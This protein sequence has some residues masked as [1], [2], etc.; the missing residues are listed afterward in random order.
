MGDLMRQYWI[1]ALRSDELPSPDCPPLRVRLLG[2]DLIAFRDHVRR[3]RPDAERL[4][5]PRRLDVL[6]PQRRRR[7]ALRLPR[8]EVR[9]RPAPASTCRP[10]RPSRNFKNKV[11]TRGL[12]DAASA[13]ASSGPTWARART[14]PPLP[15]LE[16]N[17][18]PTGERYIYDARSAS[19]TGCRAWRATSTPST[20]PSC[21]AAPR[22]R[23]GHCEPG[24]VQLLPGEQSR[25]ALQRARTR[26]SARPTAPTA[27]PRK[28][29]TTGASRH[30]L[31]PFYAMI[32]TGT[33]GR[34]ACA[35]A[36]TCRWTTTTR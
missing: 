25:A 34:R 23:R 2:E 24:V 1:P 6:R 12:P 32:P 8:L 13:A 4:P 9:R 7:P 20:S 36:P 35:S 30:I 28:T 19:A 17:M 3:G 22:R 21:T 16:A 26:S 33:L 14:P 5:A 15:D 27:R 18:L 29:A 31:F 11:R 10:S